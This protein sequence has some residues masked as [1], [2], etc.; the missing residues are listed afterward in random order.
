VL[1]R[2]FVSNG[3]CFGYEVS[4]IKTSLF[5]L[6]TAAVLLTGRLKKNLKGAFGKITTLTIVKV[7][8]KVFCLQVAGLFLFVHFI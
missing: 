2:I 4:S 5:Y 1:T 8:V 3:Y 6:I 7:Q